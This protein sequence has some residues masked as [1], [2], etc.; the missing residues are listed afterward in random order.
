MNTKIDFGTMR[1]L[2]GFDLY[3]AL[4]KVINEHQKLQV[5]YYVLVNAKADPFNRNVIR[6]VL[7]LLLNPPPVPLLNSMLFKVDNRRGLLERISL[8]PKDMSVPINFL[9][10]G[11]QS[12]AV[13]E[14]ARSAEGLLILADV[15][16]AASPPESGV[17]R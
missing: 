6:T 3:E 7:V 11:S 8:L 17:E 5:P 16:G 4:Q 12:Q 2:L 13:A 10:E 15:G 1:S 9:A 14:I